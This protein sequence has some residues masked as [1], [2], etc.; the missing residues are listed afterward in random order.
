[1]DVYVVQINN[2]PVIGAAADLV[3]AQDIA[4]RRE[5]DQWPYPW[6]EWLHDPGTGKW[7]RRAMGLQLQTIVTTPLAGWRSAPGPM[8]A[9]EAFR[10]FGTP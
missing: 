7:S 9:V 8:A 1:M 3:T 4:D 5:H 2:G 10:Y 6:G